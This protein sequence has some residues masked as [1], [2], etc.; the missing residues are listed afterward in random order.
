MANSKTARYEEVLTTE[1]RELAEH[2]E[3][4]PP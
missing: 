2:P 1:I 4:G 3:T